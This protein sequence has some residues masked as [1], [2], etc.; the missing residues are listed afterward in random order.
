MAEDLRPRI[1]AP[2]TAA[3]GEVVEIKTLISHPMESGQ[4]KDV[5]DRIVPRKILNKFTCTCNGKVVVSLNMGTGIAANPYI[6]FYLKAMESG[7]LE[8]TW[9]DD[10]GTQYDALHTITV[11]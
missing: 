5:A 10:D 1:K 4:R 8:F 7:Q 11:V 2:D 9:V 6:V 3:K